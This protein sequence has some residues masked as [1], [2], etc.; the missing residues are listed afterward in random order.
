ML[1]PAKSFLCI[2]SVQGGVKFVLW[3]HLLRCVMC[4]GV[5]MATLVVD[6]NSVGYATSEATQIAE[7]AWC[8]LGAP[9]ILAALWAAYNRCEAP[10]RLYLY[11]AVADFVL[12]F[13]VLGYI[14][15][16][17]DACAQLKP[18]SVGN[19]GEAFACGV[20]RTISV[21]ILAILMACNAYA[22]YIVW[23]FCEAMC[24]GG[25]AAAIQHLLFQ[26]EEKR[27][28]AMRWSH[29]LERGELATAAGLHFGYDSLAEVGPPH[30]GPPHMMMGEYDAAYNQA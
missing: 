7:T 20:A 19:G 16:A 6:A 8:L 9:I 23:S 4:A 17:R 22:I 13:L 30:G 26:V 29:P 12:D 14:F 11:Y 28:A 25:S 21:G 18:K 27:K 2:F 5:T 3:F 15:V 1:K 10:A 24:E